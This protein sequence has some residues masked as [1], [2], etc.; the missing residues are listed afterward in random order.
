MIK[1]IKNIATGD[2]KYLKL[3]KSRGLEPVLRCPPALEML[4]RIGFSNTATALLAEKQDVNP[5]LV[6]EF[7]KYL[8][9]QNNMVNDSI[10]LQKWPLDMDSVS[11]MSTTELDE[12]FLCTVELRKTLENALAADVHNRSDWHT[13]TAV[14]TEADVW[15]KHTG[16]VSQFTDILDTL[17]YT[18]S[19]AGVF[20]TL[21]QERRDI[22][23]FE[24]CVCDLR[25]REAYMQQ[26][27]SI[28]KVCQFMLNKY[29]KKSLLTV[30]R[31][32]RLRLLRDLL[33][34][35][36]EPR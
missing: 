16:K 25:A 5:T 35:P 28:W 17:G 13:S 24:A 23:A 21:D 2:P 11:A 4:K 20:L 7:L 22:K 32:L 30:F 29:G 1:I 34:S 12:L 31:K 26:F 19:R 14:D 36:R 27:T 9:I 10:V 33:D 8:E 6:K 18:S 15:V 3:N